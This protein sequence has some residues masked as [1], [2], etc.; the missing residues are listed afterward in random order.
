MQ[1]AIGID[2]GGSK[3]DAVLVDT[4]GRIVGWGRGG[5]IQHLYD[6]SDA[7]HQSYLDALDGALG[8]LRGAELWVASPTRRRQRW[9]ERIAQ[10]GE[11][12]EI[13]PVSEQKTSL[14]A[15]GEEWGVVVLA[16]TGSFVHGRSLDGERRLHFGAMGPVLGDF[17]SGY[18]IGLAGLRAAFASHWTASR[19]TSL[20]QVIPAALA[21]DDLNRIFHLIYM[22]GMERREIASLAQVVN[23]Q[24]EAGDRIAGDILRAAA[25][26]LFGLVQDMVHELDLADQEFPLVA[27]GSVAMRSRIWWERMCERVAEIAPRARPV[28]PRLMMAVGAA[29]LALRRMDVEWTPELWSRLEQTQ[30]EFLARLEQPVAPA[31]VAAGVQGEMPVSRE[32]KW[33]VGT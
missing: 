16:G 28:Q 33:S 12:C 26:A 5:Q 19:E 23:E 31:A 24:A 22:H 1:Y 10:A 29:L 13:L 30:G 6:T 25:D 8:D 18:E 32:G 27:A 2:G 21:V 11:I 4:S 20:A 15:A 3:C 14:A 17:G 9:E 7:I